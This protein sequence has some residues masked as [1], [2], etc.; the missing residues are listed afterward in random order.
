MP[1]ASL[2]AEFAS[3][4]AEFASLRAGFE[5]LHHS[6][7]KITKWNEEIGMDEVGWRNWDG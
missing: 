5:A 4:R 3:L 1:A 2:R 6:Y 7:F